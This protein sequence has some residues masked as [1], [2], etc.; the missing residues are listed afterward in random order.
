[1][2]LLSEHFWLFF[3]VAVSIAVLR[4]LHLKREQPSLPETQGRQ[5][6][7]SLSTSPVPETA[8]TR[9]RASRRS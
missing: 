6:D 4:E 8:H 1:M 7:E 5:A 3:A 2:S 9:P